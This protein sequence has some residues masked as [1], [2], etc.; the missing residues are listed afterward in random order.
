MR[1][2]LAILLASVGVLVILNSAA[3]DFRGETFL[4]DVFLAFAAVTWG[5][6][7]VLVRACLAALSIAFADDYGFRIDGRATGVS[8]GQSFGNW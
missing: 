4:G 5:L 7:S 3:A 1:R 8:P 2:L 6:Y